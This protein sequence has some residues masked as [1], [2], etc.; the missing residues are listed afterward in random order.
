MSASDFRPTLPPATACKVAGE[1]AETDRPS[2][3]PE[4]LY[5]I[6]AQFRSMKRLGGQAANKAF[7]DALSD[8][9]R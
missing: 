8:L 7:F 3:P 6:Q 1:S 9:D 2:T 5:A 4:R